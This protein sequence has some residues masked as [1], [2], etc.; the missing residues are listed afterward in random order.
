MY[1]FTEITV[2]VSLGMLLT[3]SCYRGKD[4]VTFR[5][6][7]VPWEGLAPSSRRPELLCLHLGRGGP[8]NKRLGGRLKVPLCC[9]LGLSFKVTRWLLWLQASHG[10]KKKK[11]EKEQYQPH[12]WLFSWKLNFF[13]YPLGRRLCSS[14]I[15]QSYVPWKSWR[16]KK[17]E[18]ESV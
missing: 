11:C 15:G 17:A 9:S 7:C 13:R 18:K 2:S 14:L 10:Q 16:H 8:P 5:I 1:Y 12:W 4:K 3:S 6:Y